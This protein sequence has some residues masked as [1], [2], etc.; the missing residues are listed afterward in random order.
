MRKQYFS[1]FHYKFC[2]PKVILFPFGLSVL[3][4]KVC[5]FDIEYLYPK[6]FIDIQVDVKENILFV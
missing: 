2:L 1:Y 4:E 5:D 6:T 3:H